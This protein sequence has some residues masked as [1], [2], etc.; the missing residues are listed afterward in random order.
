MWQ[1]GQ[2]ETHGGTLARVQG[3]PDLAV[4]VV[5]FE[6]SGGNVEHIL[7]GVA[8][9]VFAGTAA[10]EPRN[11]QEATAVV[12]GVAVMGVREVLGSPGRWS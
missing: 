11:W 9:V 5:I 1:M 8:L 6:R 7:L 3:G 10:F 12:V 4:G 2:R